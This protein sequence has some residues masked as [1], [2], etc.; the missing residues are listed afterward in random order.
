MSRT[1]LIALS[2][3]LGL[4]TAACNGREPTAPEAS[5]ATVSL[6]KV[7]ASCAVDV[8]PT[9][10]PLFALHEL[11]TWL[12]DA[13]DASGSTV[14]CGQVRSLDA[15]LEAVTQALNVALPGVP[16]FAAACG[17]SGALVNQLET[18]VTRGALATPSFPPPF[19][20]GP[21]NVL[22]AAQDLSVRWCAAARG[23]L[24]GPQM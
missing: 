13:I 24:V 16:N 21:T 23:E 12:N 17:A 2:G 14:N 6:A 1:R 8:G 9:E 7:G 19:P 20:G 18:L 22:T 15:K 5:L 10:R 4:L 11:E 3:A